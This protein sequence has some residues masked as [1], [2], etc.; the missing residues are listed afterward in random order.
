MRKE[1]IIYLSHFMD[2][3]TPLYGGNKG[4]SVT[5]D[6]SI[7]QG[8]TANTKQLSLHNHSGTHID[9]PNHFFAEG[10]TL[11]V[12][13]ASYWIFEHPYLL[14]KKCGENEIIMLDEYELDKI[15]S[16]TDFLIIKTSFGFYRNEEKY[17]KYNPGLSPELADQL[18]ER[19]PALRVLGVDLISITSFENRELG[20]VAHRKFLSGNNPILLV[21]DMNLSKLKKSPQKLMCFPLMIKKLDGAPV[22]IIAEL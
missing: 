13:D 20:R 10:A 5:P 19:L 16:N 14:Q 12:Y 1:S 9:F 4:V 15:P 7:P 3:Y 18:R 21:E 6:R 22:T 2:E 11:E 8:D 17:C